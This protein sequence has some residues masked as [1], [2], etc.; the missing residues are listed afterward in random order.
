M[1][2]LLGWLSAAEVVATKFEVSEVLLGTGPEKL[3]IV[4]S[5]LR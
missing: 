2:R 5:R 4:P 1:K 3:S